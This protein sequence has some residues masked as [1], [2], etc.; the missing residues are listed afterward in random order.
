MLRWQDSTRARLREVLP[1]GL[2]IL[3]MGAIE[4]HGPHLGT[5]TDTVL[6]GT[7]AERAAGR[8]A[9]RAD[10]DLVLAPVLPFG[11]SDHHLPFGGTLSLSVPTALAVVSDLARSVV[12]SAGRRLV[13]VNGHGGNRGVCHAAA[14]AVSSRHGLTVTV[15]H[16]WELL[17]PAGAPVPGHAGEFET[18][19]ML[20]TAPE[21]VADRSPRPPL[22]EE[23]TVEGCDMHDP[24]AWL[25]IDGYTDE[26]AAATAER[27][28]R[29]LEECVHALADRLVRLARLP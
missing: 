25:R 23:S 22:P 4:Q 27:G 19:M 28:A 29:W 21:L 15:V 2:V 17:A 24:K 1:D 6:A 11:A 9:D 10:R 18:A 26:P 3:P 5:G 14:S 16:Y 13:L 8:A 20:A 7:V 12:E